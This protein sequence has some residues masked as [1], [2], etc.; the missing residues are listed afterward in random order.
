MLIAQQ[1]AWWSSAVNQGGAIGIVALL[2]VGGAIIGRA[3][4]L[5]ML[6]TWLAIAKEQA[7]MAQTLKESLDT[8]VELQREARRHAEILERMALRTPTQ[9][10]R[11]NPR[12][13]S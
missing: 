10:P 7:A 3:V 1:D 2:L 12:S 11:P 8:A 9:T 13:G 5:P 6:T 4:A